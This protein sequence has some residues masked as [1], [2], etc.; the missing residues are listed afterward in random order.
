[1]TVLKWVLI[2]FG[3][4]F[5]A[6]AAVLFGGYY[7]ASS[8]ESVRITASDLEVGGSYPDD[9]REALSAICAA[10]TGN[11]GDADTG[12]R[13]LADKAGTQL[14]RF[15]RLLLTA[16]YKGSATQMVALTKGLLDSGIPESE[17]DTLEVKSKERVDELM[18]ECGL[19]K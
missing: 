7:W 6:V 1:M 3:V 15:E 9:E 16:T 17:L 11:T 19:A 4:L 10:K 13:C 14:S 2:I 12:C 18:S 5:L 8:I